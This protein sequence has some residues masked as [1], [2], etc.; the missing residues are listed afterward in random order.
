MRDGHYRKKVVHPPSNR[1]VSEY[2]SRQLQPGSPAA[3]GRGRLPLLPPGPDGV[4]RS[5]VA[6]DLTFNA[7]HSH[8]DDTRSNLSMGIQPRYS[9]LR[10]TGH[11]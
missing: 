9:G 2:T 1:P 8:T 6:Q 11:R 10:V 5:H 7:A 3:H 4:R